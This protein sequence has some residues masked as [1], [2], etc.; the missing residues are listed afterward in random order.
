[1]S[2]REVEDAT[3]GLVGRLSQ[4]S[5]P[6]ALTACL[7]ALNQHLAR[8]PACKAITWQVGPEPS[9]A[10][11]PP[12]SVGRKDASLP[13]CPQEKAAVVLLRKRRAFR[14]NQALQSALRETLALIGYVDPVT[15]RGIRVLSIDG[16][17]TR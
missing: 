1:M 5:S 13:V 12:A 15:G 9:S 2:H 4:A 7:R 3:R 6:D 17:G 14:D 8:H 10:W 16:G 11:V